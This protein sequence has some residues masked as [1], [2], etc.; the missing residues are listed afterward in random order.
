MTILGFSRVTYDVKIINY[1]W[2]EHNNSEK[3]Q[4]NNQKYLM[5]RMQPSNGRAS[6]IVNGRNISRLSTG[7][8]SPSS[9]QTCCTVEITQKTLEK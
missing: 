9:T 7:T 6:S 1:T 8:S 5:D 2:D 4:I 3:S